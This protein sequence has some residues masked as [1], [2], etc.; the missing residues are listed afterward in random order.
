MF[1]RFYKILLLSLFAYTVAFSQAGRI[2][3]K[4]VDQDTGEPLVGA[5]IILIGTSLGAATDINGEY[6]INNVSAGEYNVRASYIG[7]QDVTLTKLTVTSGLTAEA[8]FK[9]MLKGFSTSDVVI[10]SERPLIEKSSTNAVR[11]I[12]GD[13][14]SNLAE[15]NLNAVVALQPGVVR[16]NGLTFIRGSRPDETGYTV[17]GADVKD[18]LNRNGGSLVT[19][20][21]DAL[22]EV[23]VQAGGYTAEF[24]N[25]NAGIVSSELKTGTNDYKFSLRAETDNFGN[26]PGEKFL[27]THS[28]GYS[29]YVFT[30]S[31]PIIKDKLK[32]FISGENA[33]M[34]DNN[35][36]FFDANPTAFSDGALLDTTKVYD[37]GFYGGSTSEY[38]YLTW[39]AGNIPGVMDNR[40][41]VNGTVLFDN[42]PFILRL[43]TAFTWQGQRTGNTIINM[44]DTERLGQTDNSNLLLS[45]KGTYILPASSFIEANVSYFDSR[46]K[47]YDPN[48]EDNYL[49]YADSLIG[50]QYGWEYSNYVTDPDNYDFYGFP[51]A[52]PGS[53]LSQFR[54]DHNNYFSGSVAYTGQLGVHALK[55]GGSFQR[56]TVRRYQQLDASNLLSVLRGNPDA[57]RDSLAQLIGTTLFTNFNNYGFDVFGNETDEDGLFAPKHPVLGSAYLVDRIEVN[58]LI[59]NAGLRYD[60]ID[61]DSWAWTDPTLPIIDRIDHTIPDSALTEGDKFSYIS[62]RL[63]F[64]FPVTD[65][66][67]FHLQYG[68]FV[69]SP[70]LDVA[71][72]GVY[73]AAR[74][75]QGANLFTNP[76]AYNPQPIRTTQYE[77]GFSHQFTDFA[78]FDITAFYKDIKGQL[79]YAVVNTS[80]GALRSKYNVFANQDFST[81]KGVEISFKLRRIERVRADFNYTYSSAQGTNSLSNSGIGS[82][83]VNGE[84]PTVLIPLDY[85]QTHRGSIFLDYS[86]DPGDGGAILENSGINVLFTFNSGHPFTY[87]QTSGLGQSS[88]WTGGLTPIGT[89]DTRGRRPIGPINSASTPWVYNID[90]R[91]HKTV[92]IWNLE[93][94]F[95]ISVQ[96]LLNTKNVV[97]V[98]DKTGN[99]FDDGFLNSEEGQNI[100]AGSRYTERFADLYRA[101]NYGN[102]Q[103]AFNVYGYDLFGAPRQLRVGVLINY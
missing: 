35:P 58:D 83:E 6:L 2:S 65:Q 69:Q 31:G 17:E 53:L 90:L 101:I 97:N 84:V 100:I 64:A 68:K 13:D 44:F 8:D 40:Y 41:T 87:S 15:R 27:G 76:I 28:Y 86:F 74:I 56:W 59:I 62:P 102:R 93:C 94:D 26:Y 61:M 3:G 4:V 5:N 75:I 18:V 80:P 7:Y 1:P 21:S 46:T 81:N 36:L 88:A 77:I 25:A 29:N 63:G 33:F 73:Q 45:L 23:L 70:S 10:V 11:I 71:Y 22:Q 98:Y 99:A 55:V 66:T 54:K 20:T 60:Y 50:S 30:L 34:R 14:F 39:N 12:G 57:A 19:V 103:A 91:V 89:G 9:L 67:V 48:F 42:N 24:G 78:A 79:Q 82:T 51:F 92:D 38:Q 85:N 37:T 95:Y 52:R 49:A 96:N 43:A 47:V 32:V 72:R 16:Q